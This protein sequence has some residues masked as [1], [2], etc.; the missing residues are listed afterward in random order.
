MELRQRLGEEQAA[1]MSAQE[2][3]RRCEGA[4]LEARLR[5]ESTA[6]RN[7]EIKVGMTFR[8]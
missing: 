3:R 8:A 6:Q 2:E 7:A 5:E 4:A 1:W